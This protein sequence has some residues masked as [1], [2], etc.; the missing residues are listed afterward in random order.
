MP[1]KQRTLLGVTV[2]LLGAILTG[3]S[4]LGIVVGP[5]KTA[6]RPAI[7]QRAVAPTMA[8]APTLPTTPTPAPTIQPSPAATPAYDHVVVVV[9]ENR[10]LRTVSGNSEAPYLNAFAAR[11]ALAT[12]YSG[13]S[14]PSL[15]NY[16]AL[17]GGSTFGVASDCSGCFIGASSLADRVEAA[18]LTWRAYNE[19]MP[20]PCFGGDAYPYAQKH[21]PFYYYNSIRQNPTRCSNIVPLTSLYR[22]FATPASTPA[23][24]LVTP[25]LCNDGHDCSLATTDGWLARFVPALMSSPGFGSGRSL[26]VITYDEAEGGD[27]HVATIFAGSGVRSGFTSAGR[28]DHYSLLRTVED[29]LR[30]GS[31]GR[32]DQAATSMKEFFLSV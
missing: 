26:L 20:S 7:A 21:D 8:P 9:L 12:G 2:L 4:L 28:Y 14:H 32:E 17:T 5:P 31:L 6:G 25:N 16:L 15:P 19:S 10:S 30:L 24:S 18:G 13:V 11:N 3:V 29:S 27:D 1:S 23:F 22:D